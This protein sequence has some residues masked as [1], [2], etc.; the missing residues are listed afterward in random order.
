M[1]VY[2]RCTL[3]SKSKQCALML[4]NANLIK[5]ITVLST[6]AVVNSPQEDILGKT[7]GTAPTF[8]LH[9][10]TDHSCSDGSVNFKQICH[11]QLSA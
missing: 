2:K 6:T 10:L 4:F 11:E 1:H 9:F 3:L 5:A 8:S 7:V